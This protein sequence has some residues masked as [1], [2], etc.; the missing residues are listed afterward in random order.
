MTI[1]LSIILIIQVAIVG[2]EVVK[3]LFLK[4]KIRAIIK[5]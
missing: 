4:Q 5:I 2:V 1:M 3:C